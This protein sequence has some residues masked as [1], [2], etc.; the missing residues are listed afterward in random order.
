QLPTNRSTLTTTSRPRSG[1]G[2]SS[3]IWHNI[4]TKRSMRPA[5]PKGAR[6]ASSLLSSA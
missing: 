6:L 4:Q 2:C 3:R 1:M 5:A